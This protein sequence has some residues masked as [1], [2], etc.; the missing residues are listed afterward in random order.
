MG[1]KQKHILKI[2]LC[3]CKETKIPELSLQYLFLVPRLQSLELWLGF[4][5]LCRLLSVGSHFHNMSTSNSWAW[6]GS[7]SLSVFLNFFIWDCKVFWIGFL[8]L[9]Y[10]FIKDMLLSPC[11]RILWWDYFLISFPVYLL[12]AEGLLYVKVLSCLLLS[13]WKLL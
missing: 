8:L 12:M 9:L 5:W 3:F 2:F 4:H 1:L 13:A 11:L 6:E 7:P 10:R